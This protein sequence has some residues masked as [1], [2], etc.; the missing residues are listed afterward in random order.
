MSVYVDFVINF[1]QHDLGFSVLA[2]RYF[3]ALFIMVT[4]VVLSRVVLLLFN[5]YL[6]Q[7]AKKTTTQFD[8]LIFEQ[9]KQP[10]FF[11]ILVLGLRLALDYVGIDDGFVTV[12][13]SALA[14]LFLYLVMKTIDVSLETWGQQIAR[15]T[16][17]QIDEVLLPFLHKIVKVLFV[18]IGLIWLLHI[19]GI[20]VTPY[21]AGVG[22]SGIVLGLALQDSLKNILG[23]ISLLLDKTYQVG[24]KVALE[25][26]D[27][28]QIADIGLRSTKMVTYDN[29]VV[30]IP[31]GYMANSRVRNF[32]RP[33]PSVRVK[34]DFGVEYGSNVVMV[35]KVVL[36]VF[37]SIEGIKKDPAPAVNFLSM[38]DF[39]L[40]FR[41]T[42]WIPKWDKEFSKKVEATE[43]IYDALNKA[44]IG[45]PFPTQTVLVK[46]AGG[47]VSK[48]GARKLRAI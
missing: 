40:K 9:T 30:Y 14:L 45:I 10:I 29:E 36:K 46:N 18:I 11:F 19:W 42:F 3:A 7:V 38:G 33:D 26:G 1:F 20:N 13:T 48:V 23:G 32:T 16:S 28:G 25:N 34:V 24:D 6:K 17:T 43:K 47:K 5:L 8:D 44:K 22:I 41:A 2:N 39:A 27:V 35:R 12:V 37:S 15:K 4:A 21:L 31:N